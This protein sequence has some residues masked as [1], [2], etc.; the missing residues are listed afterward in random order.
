MKKD[1]PRKKGKRADSFAPRKK[2]KHAAEKKSKGKNGRPERKA[3]TAHDMKGG[4]HPRKKCQWCEVFVAPEVNK[5]N[6]PKRIP[7]G[8]FGQGPKAPK[9]G[10][11]ALKENSE[12]GTE[13]SK[14]ENQRSDTLLS[15]EGTEGQS[16]SGG[17]KH[18][19]DEKG[20]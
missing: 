4:M 16:I 5:K 11:D 19:N 17:R 9:R 7:Y 18:K 8:S 3:E 20:R 13:D 2:G 14:K 1:K 15:R 10:T 6:D 12:H